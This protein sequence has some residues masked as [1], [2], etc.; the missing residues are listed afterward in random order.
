[1]RDGQKCRGGKCGTG[2]CGTNMQGWK[3]RNNRVWKACLRISLSNLM[4]ECKNGIGFSSFDTVVNSSCTICFV[5][6]CVFSVCLLS[7][8]FMDLFLRILTD[9]V[10]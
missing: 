5:F 9:V 1:M 4:L 3:L 7:A 6:T 8:V 10:V 2:K